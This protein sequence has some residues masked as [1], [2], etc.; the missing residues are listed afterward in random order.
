MLQSLFASMTSANPEKTLSA[1]EGFVKTEWCLTF[2]SIFEK[3]PRRFAIHSSQLSSCTHRS[4]LIIT[5]VKGDVVGIR[6]VS[7]RLKE[8]LPVNDTCER[9]SAKISPKGIVRTTQSF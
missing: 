9:S 7:L 3:L 1:M 5:K 8:Q 4:I 6:R 2:D